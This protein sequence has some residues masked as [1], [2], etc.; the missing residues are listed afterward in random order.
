MSYY[1]PIESGGMPSVLKVVLGVLIG[2]V[3][4][5]FLWIVAVFGLAGLASGTSGTS[6]SSDGF[7][8]VAA[9]LPLVV[10]AL[11]LI[12]RATRP[13]A[14][15]IMMGTAVTSIGMSSICASLVGA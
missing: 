15:G 4:G 11:L 12:P 10:P 13:W 2:L 1:Q 7:F 8:F 6:D 9:V 3:G 5:F 14:V